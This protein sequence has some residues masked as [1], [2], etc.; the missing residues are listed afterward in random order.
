MTKKIICSYMSIALLIYLFGCSGIQPIAQQP[1]SME[2]RKEVLSL[3]ESSQLD[4]LLRLTPT[5]ALKQAKAKE[6]KVSEETWEEIEA[7][8]QQSQLLEPTHIYDSMT[9]VFWDQGFNSNEIKRIA[10]FYRKPLGKKFANNMLGI[11]QSIYQQQ[12]KWDSLLQQEIRE[13]LIERGF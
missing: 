5:K 4:T 3:I 6:K 2:Y 13:K 7:S 8:L 1:F 9:Q 12:S 11:Y 10:H